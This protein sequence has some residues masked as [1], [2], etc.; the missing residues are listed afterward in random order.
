MA[1]NIL[2]V[3]RDVQKHERMA[4]MEDEKISPVE[5]D[6]FSKSMPDGK[7]LVRAQRETGDLPICSYFYESSTH[8]AWKDPDNLVPYWLPPEPSPE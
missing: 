5:I 2:A 7:I 4:L 3:W 6:T 1:Y 8:R